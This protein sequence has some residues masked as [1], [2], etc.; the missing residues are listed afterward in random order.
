MGGLMVRDLRLE[1]PGMERSSTDG[2]TVYASR[3]WGA[4]FPPVRVERVEATG[5]GRSG[6]SIGSWAGRAGFDGI[7]LADVDA[8]D[9]ALGGILTYA[10]ERAAH[11]GVI[12]RRTR[13]WGNPGRAGLVHNSGNG[14]VVGGADGG[15]IEDSVAHDNGGRD[16]AVEGG[17][18]IWA[19]DSRGV[20]I[21]RNESYDNRTGGVADGGGF[22]LDLGV[23]DSVIQYNH[24]HD[25]DGAGYLIANPSRDPVHA[26]NV[27]RFNLSER[28][29]RRNG[30]P[31][32][33]IWR[34][35][36]RLDVY[37]NTVVGPAPAVRAIELGDGS[38]ALRDNLFLRTSAGPIL[39]VAAGATA[40]AF[41]GNAYWSSAG[42]LSFEWAAR[43]YGGLG[44]WRQAS[45]QER[46]GDAQTGLAMDPQLAGGT[47]A[48]GVGAYAPGP[49]SPLIDAA[50]DL[51][52]FGINAGVRDLLGTS[53]PVASGLDIGALEATSASHDPDAPPPDQASSSQPASTAPP[54]TT[55]AGAGDPT[56]PLQRARRALASP[57]LRIRRVARRGRRIRVVGSTARNLPTNAFVR[58]RASRGRA[59]G[60]SMPAS[61][62]RGH[63]T[64]VAVLPR[65][66]TGRAASVTVSYAGD[67]EHRAQRRT[68]RLRR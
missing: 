32:I 66:T 16:N 21:Q 17:V 3:P 15:L 35:T 43:R 41:Q 59:T 53:L 55:P 45:G 36:A 56:S 2:L 51:R 23:S 61:I 10:Q 50:L 14:I 44:A 65:R 34:R 49:G 5:F 63:F 24:S 37:H 62:R 8:H 54:T 25:N 30:F 7:E 33:A 4:R 60:R 13:A 20:V 39:D 19:Y 11:R 9:N 18:G 28:D 27:V 42:A 12:V 57:R 46:V 31:G 26:G 64:A 38:A 68:R 6:V 22:D 52:P 47:S 48:D 29:G 58:L 1:G 67:A 40:T